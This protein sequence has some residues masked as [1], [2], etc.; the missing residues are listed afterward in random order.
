MK[1]FKNGKAIRAA[2]ENDQ[3]A[4]YAAGVRRDNAEANREAG[5]TGPIEVHITKGEPSS[6]ARYAARVAKRAK[7]NN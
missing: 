6:A 1:D 7:R 4:M 3:R 2:R 5:S